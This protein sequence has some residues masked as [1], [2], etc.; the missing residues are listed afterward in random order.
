METH[1]INYRSS[2]ENDGLTAEG[3]KS[4]NQHMNPGY[5]YTQTRKSTNRSH[6]YGRMCGNKKRLIRS[7]M[8][9]VSLFLVL[10]SNT[11]MCAEN[12]IGMNTGTN[13]IVRTNT[14]AIRRETT[15]SHSNKTGTQ[16]IDKGYVSEDKFRVF[17]CNEESDLST[18]EFSLNEPPA[19]R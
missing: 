16:R 6:R 9:C 3:F 5:N 10:S 2:K 7:R 18:V 17:E 19:C 4:G 14:K 11:T 13:E 15:E 12:N 1:E 8:I